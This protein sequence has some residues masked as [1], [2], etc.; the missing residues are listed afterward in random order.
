[1]RIATSLYDMRALDDA[2]RQTSA[3]HRVHPLAKLAVT[4]AYLVAAA[5]FGRYETVRL[6][7]LFFY[8]VVVWAAAELPL[9]PILKR[10]LLAGPLIL[11]IGA[12]NPLFDQRLVAVGG[13]AVAQGWLAFLSIAVKCT[14]TVTAALLLLAT[15]GMDRLA[16]ALRMLRVPRLFVLQLLLTYRYISVLMEETGRTLLAYSLRAPRQKGVRPGAWGPLAGQLLLRTYDRSQ[17]VYQ[18]MRL[19]GFDGEYRTGGEARVRPADWAYLLGWAAFFAVLR[20]YDVPVTLGRL[21]TGAP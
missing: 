2:A 19:R 18:A 17:R 15:T 16:A 6:L 13:V 9:R 21:L 5:S 14:L 10:V 12:L 7:P 3:V 11:G 1:M 4:M 20:M 8:P